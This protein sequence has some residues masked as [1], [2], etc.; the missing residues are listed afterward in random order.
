MEPHST[1]ERTDNES[2]KVA[3]HAIE[4]VDPTI[5]FPAVDS[6]DPNRAKD[7]TDSELCRRVDPSTLADLIDA[8]AVSPSTDND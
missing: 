1:A 5:P 4:R 8:H 6:V 2:V 7:C 3:L